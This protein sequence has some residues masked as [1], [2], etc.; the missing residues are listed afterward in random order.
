VGLLHADQL[1]NTLV[2][3]ALNL[4]VGRLTASVSSIHVEESLRL[5]KPAGVIHTHVAHV[6]QSCDRHFRASYPST[7]T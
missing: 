2:L 6:S 1:A 3:D 4:R 7:H 5:A